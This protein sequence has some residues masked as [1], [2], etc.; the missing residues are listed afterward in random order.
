MGLEGSVQPESPHKQYVKDPILNEVLNHTMPLRAYE[1][2][3]GMGMYAATSHASIP[4]MSTTGVGEMMPET[5]LPSFARGMS[6]VPTARPQ[7]LQEGQE[8]GHV[9]MES[10]PEGLSALDVAALVTPAPVA[11]AMTDFSRMRAIL[12]ASKG[13]RS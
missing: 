9:P 11:R 8:S 10:I 4:M 1:K 3:K 12:E 13:R 5:E 7:V 2:A 6:N